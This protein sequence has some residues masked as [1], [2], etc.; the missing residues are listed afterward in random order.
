MSQDKIY[1]NIYSKR[2]KEFRESL[3]LNQKEFADKIG[4]VQP[5]VSRYE[6]GTEPKFTYLSKIANTFGHKV[7]WL[8]TGQEPL[9]QENAPEIVFQTKDRGQIK[10]MTDLEG[11]YLAVPLL[12]DRVAA[13]AP[14]DVN[15]AD[16]ESWAI[17]YKDRTWMPGRQ[18]DYTCVR[19]QG[20]SMYPV[21][22]NGDIVAIDHSAARDCDREA[23]LRLD[24]HMVAF[25]IDGGVTI[26]W[27][28]Y[29]PEQH[30]V[31]G[32]PENRDEMDHAVSLQGSKIAAGI[33]G[34]VR[35]WWSK[36]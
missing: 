15:E 31:I 36:R 29:F 2:L 11:N 20:R 19:V 3:G 12:A 27:L 21:L 28:K 24:G 34:L 16:V 6:S 33:V 32:V 22:D 17:I 7:M 10:P 30:L 8:L 26:K 1:N 35:W 23:L 5:N 14:A 25:R 18:G 13:G 9:Q 4:E